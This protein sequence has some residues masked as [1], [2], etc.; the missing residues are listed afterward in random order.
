MKK[1]QVDRDLCIGCC[2]CVDFAG[3]FFSIKDGLAYV[4][5]QPEEDEADDAD[6]AID[7]CPTEAIEWID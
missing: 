4:E 5:V 7:N 1:L 6:I 3:Q 2:R